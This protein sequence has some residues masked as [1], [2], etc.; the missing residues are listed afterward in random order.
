MRPRCSICGAAR[1]VSAPQRRR[2]LLL[3]LRRPESAPEYALRGDYGA[4]NPLVS[5]A[6]RARDFFLVIGPPGTGK[7][8]F[9]MLNILKEELLAPGS[10]VLL[11]AYTNRAVDEMCSKLADSG[12]GFVRLGSRLACAEAYR[13]S[14]LEQRAAEMKASNLSPGQLM[15]LEECFADGGAR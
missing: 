12:I 3:G 15:T 1:R 14:L 10:A 2:D 8:S 4:F 6:M 7:T 11:M 9:A 5:R 13:D